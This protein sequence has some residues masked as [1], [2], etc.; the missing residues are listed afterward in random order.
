MK[1]GEAIRLTLFHDP[2]RAKPYLTTRVGNK[3]G[4]AEATPPQ[5]TGAS[6]AVSYALR[7]RQVDAPDGRFGLFSSAC[8]TGKFTSVP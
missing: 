4:A 3:G 1:K 6:A 5:V 2:P 8:G 7:S